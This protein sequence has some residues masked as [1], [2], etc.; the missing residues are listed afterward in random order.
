MAAA[1]V[2]WERDHAAKMDVIMASQPTSAT[3]IFPGVTVN[4]VPP[5]FVSPYGIQ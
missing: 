1:E 3:A 2:G 5:I 4:P